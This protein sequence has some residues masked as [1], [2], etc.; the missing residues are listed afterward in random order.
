[1]KSST[2]GFII[3]LSLLALAVGGVRYYFIPKYYPQLLKVELASKDANGVAADVQASPSP[4]LV[5]VGSIATVSAQLLKTLTPRQ[6]VAQLLSAPITVPTNDKAQSI[7]SAAASVQNEV[8]GFM[9]LFGQNVSA[10][11][12]DRLTKELKKISIQPRMVATQPTLS[13]Q[14]RQFLN[15]LIAVDHEGG[16]VQRLTGEGMTVLPSAMEQCKLQREELLSLLG[17]AAKELNGVGVDIVFAPVVD[18]GSDHPILK[19]R[20][21]SDNADLVRSYGVF[22]IDAMQSEHIIPVIKHFPGIGQTSVDLHKKADVITLDPIENS[23]FLGLLTT[24][25]RIGVMTTHVALKTDDGSTPLPCTVS[26]K[27]LEN[28]RTGSPRLIFTDGLEMAAAKGQ[29]QSSSS[30]TLSESSLQDQ[31]QSLSGLAISAIEAGHNVIV[32]GKT[33]QRSETDQI[34]SDLADRYQ[35]NPVFKQKVDQALRTIWQAKYE[36]WSALGTLISIK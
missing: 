33:V 20:L 7:A 1:M 17:R 18:L 32:L 4:S 15:P 19:T 3:L 36:Q 8:P 11:Q 25:P 28:L 26:E 16:S 30:A 2:T 22:W 5:P 9:T 29:S 10:L 23:I 14:E 35:R 34:V 31:K 6:K 13:E 12:A 24:Y 27:C 21:C